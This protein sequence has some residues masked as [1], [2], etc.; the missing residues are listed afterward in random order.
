MDAREWGF[1]I[2][3]PIRSLA[4]RSSCNLPL[5]MTSS[6]IFHQLSQ[7]HRGPFHLLHLV[8]PKAVK[9]RCGAG[10]D[11][12]TTTTRRTVWQQQCSRSL[13]L[14]RSTLLSLLYSPLSPHTSA[15]LN[16]T[17]TRAEGGGE[18]LYGNH[19]RLW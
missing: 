12:P 6:R 1:S 5:W 8:D 2:I 9:R 16:S 11:G 13:A 10:G 4:G 3:L 19:A 15:E 17:C 7:N 18:I 14:H